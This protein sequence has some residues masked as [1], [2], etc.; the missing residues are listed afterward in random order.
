MNTHFDRHSGGA[1]TPPRHRRVAAIILSALLVAPGIAVCA[2]PPIGLKV[3]LQPWDPRTDDDSVKTVVDSP[4]LITSELSKTWASSKQKVIDG[5]TKVL[6]TSDLIRKGVTLYDIKININEPELRFETGPNGALKATMTL[7]DSY[8]EATAT[9]PTALGSYADPRCSARFSLDLSVAIR[10]NDT[11]ARLFQ[12]ALGAND[13]IVTVRSFS[14]DSQN[15]ACDVIN[16]ITSVTGI[17]QAVESM[18]NDPNRPEYKALNASLRAAF[19]TALGAVNA[20]VAVPAQYVRLQ[21]WPSATKPTV[22]FGVREFPVPPAA[23]RVG[24]VAGHV[25]VGDLK[26]L[27]MPI[28]RCDQLGFTAQIKT[29]P[30]P[31]LNAAATD[32]G[33]PPM[34]NVDGVRLT[35]GG[36]VASGAVRAVQPGSHAGQSCDY[37]LAGMVPG[38]PNFLTFKIANQVAPNPK[39][40]TPNLRDVVDVMPQ[41]WKF[42]DALHPIP[43]IDGRDLSLV[44]QMHGSVGYAAKQEVFKPLNPGDPQA[45]V[46]GVASRI[47]TQPA[48]AQTV[49]AKPATSAKP[50]SSLTTAASTFMST[51]QGAATT[52]APQWGGASMIQRTS[53][54]TVSS[55]VTQTG[56]ALSSSALKA[57]AS[58]FIR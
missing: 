16:A 17:K 45:R 31:V 23:L 1:R 35:G 3:M 38:F 21:M 10:V 14:A 43:R 51:A 39:S 7:N 25:T 46:A 13:R 50:T 6:G 24:T 8:F 49:T 9:Q 22:L 41:G 36:F 26:D 30:R 4:D 2:P 40:P 15:F 42:A 5:L 55:P 48:V 28:Q 57:P 47:I 29:G 19:D 37:A 32:F 27:P 34:R 54:A 44:A 20:K 33:D 12:S 56:A 53:P 11:P 52:T 18:I 58:A